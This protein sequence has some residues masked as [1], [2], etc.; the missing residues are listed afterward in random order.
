MGKVGRQGA[1]KENIPGGSSTEEQRS[2]PA[3][4]AK[5][6]RALGLLQFARVGSALTARRGDPSWPVRH[7][8]ALAHAKIPLR[9]TPRNF[10]S[11]SQG[12]SE[13]SVGWPDDVAAGVLES[14]RRAGISARQHTPIHQAMRFALRQG[15]CQYTD[16]A[17]ILAGRMPALRN[18]SSGIWHRVSG[19]CDPQQIRLLLFT[20]GR[21]ILLHLLFL[22][23]LLGKESLEQLPTFRLAHSCRD[24][25]SMIEGRELQ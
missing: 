4:P 15:G 11:G 17:T 12:Q 9:R 25:A 3:F 21:R 13:N 7:G 2:Q 24:L 6:R 19:I 8:P 23:P 18:R 20:F 14:A 10:Q 22:S 5:T 16:F 1:T